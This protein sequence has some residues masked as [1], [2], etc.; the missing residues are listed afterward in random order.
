MVEMVHPS[1]I[2][3]SHKHEAQPTNPNDKFEA[4]RP[5]SEPLKFKE[6]CVS[7]CRVCTLCPYDWAA[8]G[9]TCTRRL[10]GWWRVVIMAVWLFAFLMT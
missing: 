6:L 7:K 10:V 8:S 2:M 1:N 5:S 3:E 9:S 4:D